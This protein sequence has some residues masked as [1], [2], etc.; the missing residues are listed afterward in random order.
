VSTVPFTPNEGAAREG[1]VE[2]GVTVVLKEIYMPF[3]SSA[4]EES[5]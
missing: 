1:V 4:S 3:T 2:K 5:H